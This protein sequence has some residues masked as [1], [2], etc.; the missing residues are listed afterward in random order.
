MIV[1]LKTSGLDIDK[2]ID[3]IEDN[4]NDF[5]SHRDWNTSQIKN[6]Y[7]EYKKLV[8]AGSP[9]WGEADSG[10]IAS[11]IAAITTDDK[12]T[13]IL[14]LDMIKLLSER[15]IIPEKFYQITDNKVLP[16]YVSELKKEKPEENEGFDI[17]SL[18]DNLG[19]KIKKAANDAGIPNI[20]DIS[21]KIKLA[22]YL[23]LAGTGFYFIGI[24]VLKKIM[25]GGK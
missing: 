9:R 19:T 17:K 2:I 18:L 5:Y 25:K 15:K 21:K 8:I 3:Q 1:R 23:A 20:E 6:I 12:N 16:I 14:I 24:P 10:P 4:L 13:V 11:K 7:N 22:G